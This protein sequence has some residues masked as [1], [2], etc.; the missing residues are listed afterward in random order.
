M[1]NTIELTSKDFK[2]VTKEGVSLIDFWAP[3]CGPCRMV[4][5]VLEDLADD[6]KEKVKI[7]KINTDIEQDLAIKYQV[8]SIPT[9]LFMKD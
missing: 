2:K 8:K 4:A 7:C 3:W 6:F 9:L 1:T 5:P